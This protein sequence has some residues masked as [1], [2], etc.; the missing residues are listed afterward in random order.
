M[1]HGWN[2]RNIL[3]WSFRL[4][5]FLLY[6]SSCLPWLRL[7]IRSIKSFLILHKMWEHNIVKKLTK[8]AFEKNILVSHKR[9]KNP[10]FFL[11]QL[12]GFFQNSYNQSSVLLHISR[13]PH[14]D[15]S[16]SQSGQAI[17]SLCP[18]TLA[19]WQYASQQQNSLLI[20]KKEES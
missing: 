10:I 3:R 18:S 8:S 7:D 20:T 15:H 9:L 14:V 13:N 1:W 12:Q 4:V 11:K 6:L 16:L 2:L 17:Y 19:Q 5:I